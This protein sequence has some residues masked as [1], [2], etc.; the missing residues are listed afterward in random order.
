MN[1]QPIILEEILEAPV[2]KVW[3]AITEITEIKKWYFDLEEFKPEVGFIFK[4]FGGPSPEK[5]YLHVCEITDIVPGEKLTYSW[6]YEGYAGKSFVTFE[7]I[8]HG[9]KTLLKLIHKGIDTFPKDNPDLAIEN[10]IEGWNQ[11]VNI[12]LKKYLELNK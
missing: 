3:K 11:I 7:L 8:K 6:R 12:S 10:F 1:N 5:Q 4:F 2:L 9:N